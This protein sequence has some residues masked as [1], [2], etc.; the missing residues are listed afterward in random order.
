[1]TEQGGFSFQG[2]GGQQVIC[3]PDKKL[4]FVCTGDNQFNAMAGEILYDAVFDHLSPDEKVYRSPAHCMVQDGMKE[5]AL[6]KEISG[7]W[8]ACNPNPSGITKFRLTFDGDEGVFEYENAQGEK[9]LPFGIGKNVFGKF[10]QRGYSNGRG[11]VHDENDPFLLGCAASAAW[12][13]EK[14]LMLF[15]QIIDRYF[16]TLIMTFGFRGKD[17]CGFRMVKNAEDF[18]QEYNGTLFAYMIPDQH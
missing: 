12:V 16:G 5:T 1:M 8:F 14:T 15:T 7:K 10:P 9:K 11:N 13:D 6:T 3:I 4:I 2:M 18:L 17:V